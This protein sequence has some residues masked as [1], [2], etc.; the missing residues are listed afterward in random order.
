VTLRLSAFRA[1]AANEGRWHRGCEGFSYDLPS[2]AIDYNYFR[3][4]DPKTGR[5]IT[6]DPI[7]LQGGIN[8]YAYVGG[9]PLSYVDPLGLARFGFRPLGGDEAYYNSHSTP[10]GSSNHHRA[11]EQ[12]W[13]DDNPNEN[14]GFFAGDGNGN[15]PAIC[16][17]DGDVRSEN[18]YDRSDYD[19]FG[20]VYDDN[21]M[22]QASDNIRGDWDNNTYCV[23]GMNCQH[24]SDALRQEYDRLA[25]P[26]AC[27]MTRSGMR[28]N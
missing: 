2:D 28:C 5:Y 15:G 16:G 12:L 22:R 8:T 13:F 24:F 3:Y 27:R 9:N 20:P 23:A 25:N 17:E 7:G 19:F 21:L 14:V 10:D 4:Y 6:S 26:P 18:G 11:H 1:F